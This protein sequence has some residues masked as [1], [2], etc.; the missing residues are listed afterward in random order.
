MK[1]E[2]QKTAELT[3]LCDLIAHAEVARLRNYGDAGALI[4]RPLSALKMDADGI[5]WFVADQS[6]GGF[7]NL[8]IVNVGF[9]DIAGT[10]VSIT[11][12]GEIVADGSSIERLTT[13]VANAPFPE[14]P[15]LPNFALLKVVP[16]MAEYLDVPRSKMVRIFSTTAFLVAELN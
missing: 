13:P 1:T 11:G 9:T 3:R 10:Y 14:D 8:S 5:L 7:K 15:G 2:P 16:R 12:S 6:S 4:S